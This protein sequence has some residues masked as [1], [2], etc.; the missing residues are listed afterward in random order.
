MHREKWNRIPT[1]FWTPI[2][3]SS[4]R[5][6]GRPA[7]SRAATWAHRLI[8]LAATASFAGFLKNDECTA[9]TQAQ[10]KMQCGF[11]LNVVVSKR[12]TVFEL[13]TCEY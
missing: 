1:N 4:R 3:N 9:T 8:W 11:L 10:Y 7:T 6:N 12:A 13:F 5:L 2:I